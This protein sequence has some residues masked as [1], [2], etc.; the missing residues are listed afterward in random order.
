MK[1]TANPRWNPQEPVEVTPE[2]YEKQVVSWLS[3]AGARLP[4]FSVGHLKKVQ[5]NGGEYSIDGW[6]EFEIF[7]GA[8]MSVLVECK[9]HGRPVERDVVLGVH[10]KASAVGAQKS[11]IFSTSGFQSGAVEF[12]SSVGMALVV[13]VSGKMTYETRSREPLSEQNY[14]Y[15]LLRFAGQIIQI[16]EGKTTISYVDKDRI[17]PL[18]DWFLS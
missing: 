5:G 7:D 15:D 10:A 12:A 3:S 1:S 6:V 14:P 8:K 11:M 16:S 2:A 18:S 4:K 17:A 9:R 13:F